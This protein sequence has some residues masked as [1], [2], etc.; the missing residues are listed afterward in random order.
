MSES[1]NTENR[2]STTG[3][4]IRESYFPTQIFYRDLSDAEAMNEAVKR[5]IYA[6]RARDEEGIVR[7]NVR[8]AGSWH[9]RHRGR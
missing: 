6:W 1:P 8:Q 3:E 5:E 2:G 7:S 4:L 9:S